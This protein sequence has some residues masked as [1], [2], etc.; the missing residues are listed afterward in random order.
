M[1]YH[2]PWLEK[3]QMLIVMD[4]EAAYNSFSCG[5]LVFKD[6]FFFLPCD[7]N[8]KDVYVWGQEQA[9]V[10]SAPVSFRYLGIIQAAHFYI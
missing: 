1:M 7:K 2:K 3:I 9:T 4:P 8:M 6:I 5:A 10:I